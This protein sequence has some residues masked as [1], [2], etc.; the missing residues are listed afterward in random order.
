VVKKAFLLGMAFF[1]AIAVSGFAE[2]PVLTKQQL[3]ADFA[4]LKKAYTELHPGLYRYADKATVGRYFDDLEPLVGTF[5]LTDQPDEGIVPDVLVKPA[6]EDVVKGVDTQLEAVRKLIT[7]ASRVPAAV[8]EVRKV[9]PKSGPTLQRER[10]YHFGSPLKLSAHA[11]RILPWRT[12]TIERIE[13]PEVLAEVGLAGARLGLGWGER[14]RT[15]YNGQTVS[16]NVLRTWRSIVDPLG[17][18]ADRTLVGLG[19]RII[20]LGLT[21]RGDLLYDLDEDSDPWILGWSVGVSW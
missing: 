21:L 16:A 15:Y 14:G 7:E 18:A 20:G 2:T 5:P 9:P 13:G 3:Q 6:V 8:E 11:S 19:Y 4:I 10:G 17:V 12:D 1:V